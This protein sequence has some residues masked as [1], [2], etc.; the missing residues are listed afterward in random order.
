MA[1]GKL[2]NFILFIGMMFVGASIAY[3]GVSLLLGG[4]GV[5]AFAFL[6][7]VTGIAMIIGGALLA[8]HYL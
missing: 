1:E 2:G 7:I 6:V 4:A 3:M 5:S 8:R